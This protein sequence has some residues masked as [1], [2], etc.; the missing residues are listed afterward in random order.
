MTIEQYGIKLR[1]VT[2]DDIEQIRIWRNQPEIR[3]RMAFKK[4]ITKNMQEKW[5][6]SINNKNNYYFIIH[7]EGKDIGVINCKNVNEKEAYGEGGIFISD[8]NYI[9]SMAPVF[10][11]LCLINA[12]FY[13]LKFSNKSFVQILQNNTVSISYNKSIGYSLIPGQEKLKNQWYVLTKE[14]YEIKAGKINKAAASLSGD[15]ELPRVKGTVSE[16]NLER[17]NKLF[18]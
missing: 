18:Q 14:D 3:K 15:Q 9:G 12:I 8:P 6:K 4:Y 16:I 11:T 13:V 17:I 7:Y 1:R 5:F 10:A 2:F